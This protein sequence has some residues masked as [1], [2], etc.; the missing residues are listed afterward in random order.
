MQDMVRDREAWHAAVHGVT[1]SQIQLSDWITNVLPGI[2]YSKIV[3][4]LS[5][6]PSAW[7]KYKVLSTCASHHSLAFLFHWMGF[8]CTSA[9]CTHV[10]LLR[11][12]GNHLVMY[13][14]ITP[15]LSPFRAPLKRLFGVASIKGPPVVVLKK[16]PFNQGV[17][18]L[19]WNLIFW[20][21]WSETQSSGSLKTWGIWICIWTTDL[22]DLY[23]QW[24]YRY[25]CLE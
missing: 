7:G 14:V 18:N 3:S 16:F 5:G 9:L 11:V 2:L 13:T 20:L 21:K 8:E 25:S 4:S 19:N 17:K 22:G 10:L 1:K 12:K 6:T 15:M 23:E 24:I